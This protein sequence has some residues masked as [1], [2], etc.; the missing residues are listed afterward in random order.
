[1]IQTEARVKIF[2]TFRYKTDTNDAGR[3]RGRPRT[4]DAA[5]VLDVAMTAYWHDDPADVSINA[6]CRLA[7]VSKPSLYREVGSQ[8]T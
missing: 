4:T 3:S 1:M 6:I 5:H 7:G 8:G 2:R